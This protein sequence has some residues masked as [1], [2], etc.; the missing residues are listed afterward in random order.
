MRPMFVM[1]NWKMNGSR[2]TIQALLEGILARVDGFNQA[3]NV[4][5]F[6]PAIYIPMV[7]DMLKNTRIHWGAQ[8]THEH[9]SGAYTGEISP[10]MLADYGCS[11]VL[12][13]HSERRNLFNESEKCVAKK[14]HSVK[15]HGMIPVL[16]V[17]ETKSERENGLMM[18]VLERQ[19]RAVHC[20]GSVDFQNCVVAYEPVWAIGTGQ[21][22]TPDE[23]AEAHA[24]IRDIV[25]ELA[26]GDAERL[27][28]VYGGSVNEQT[29]EALFAI[30]DIDGGLVGGASLKAEQ[31]SDIVTCI[32]CY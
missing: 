4:V 11:Y 27:S 6:P 18:S 17:G 14:F 22:A 23:A 9:E 7:A 13:G 10:A 31:F 12:V 25:T 24:C 1:G 19:L 32:N 21:T 30:P 29:A 8:T 3:A 28:I 20:D 5:V 16:C 2:K 26:P 15:E